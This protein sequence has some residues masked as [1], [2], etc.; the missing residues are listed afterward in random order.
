[1]SKISA[2]KRIYVP[3]SDDVEKVLGRI[4]TRDNKP[5]ASAA[6]DLLQMAIEIEEDSLWDKVASE[7]KAMNSRLYSHKEAWE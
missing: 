2:K 1:M 4:S 3:V 6:S 5:V 7:R